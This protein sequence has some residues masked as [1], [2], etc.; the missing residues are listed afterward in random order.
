MVRACSCVN[1]HHSSNTT[2]PHCNPAHSP[3]AWTSRSVCA[4]AP[5]LPRDACMC[6]IVFHIPT[7]RAFS[8]RSERVKGVD[9]HPTEPWFVQPVS[10]LCDVVTSTPQGARKPVQWAGIRVELQRSG[11]R[12]MTDQ[13]MVWSLRCRP[14]PWSSPLRSPRCQVRGLVDRWILGGLHDTRSSQC[15]RPSLWPASSGS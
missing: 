15:A 14:R 12:L 10:S 2:S 9:L 5:G 1:N 8:T 7:Q 6:S 3:C 11:T 13:M 4:L